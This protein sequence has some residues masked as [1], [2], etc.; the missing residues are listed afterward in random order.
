MSRRGGDVPAG[1]FTGR[2]AEWAAHRLGW[3]LEGNPQPD[4]VHIWVHPPTGRKTP[5]NPDWPA[6]YVDDPIFN[7]LKSDFGVTR[8]RL[9]RLLSRHDD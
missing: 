2:D 8:N 4:E 5:I 6:I 7:V 3:K 9:M 1:P